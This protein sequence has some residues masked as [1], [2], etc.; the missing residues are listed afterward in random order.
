MCGGLLLLLQFSDKLEIMLETL[1]TTSAAQQQME[2]ISAHVDKLHE[3][4]ADNQ[5]IIEDMQRKLSNIDSLK[6]AADEL[7]NRAG[8]EDENSKGLTPLLI[9]LFLK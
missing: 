2:P 9:C 6:T 4:I 7:L 1:A 5:A 3:Q 8:M